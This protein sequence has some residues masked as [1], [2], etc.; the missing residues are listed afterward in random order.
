LGEKKKTTKKKERHG[1]GVEDVRSLFRGR[2]VLADQQPPSPAGKGTLKKGHNQ[3]GLQ[4]IDNS[5]G[6]ESC[7]ARKER[8]KKKVDP[9]EE[10][11]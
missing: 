4:K 6:F 8:K 7:D 9:N 3:N 2:K 10:E 11:G 5:K 1:G